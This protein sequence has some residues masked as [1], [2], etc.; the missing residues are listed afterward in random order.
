MGDASRSQNK[1]DDE[2][3]TSRTPLL[4]SGQRGTETDNG[5]SSE[6]VENESDWRAGQNDENPRN[7]T[8]AYKWT[9]VALVSFIEFLTYV[10]FRT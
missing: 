10:H 4:K 9:T 2:E 8:F 3:A 7:W 6:H 1:H 5:P